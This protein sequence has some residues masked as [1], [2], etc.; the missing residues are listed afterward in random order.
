MLKKILKYKN[1]LKLNRLIQVNSPFAY[2]ISIFCQVKIIANKRNPKKNKHR[3]NFYQCSGCGSCFKNN[4]LRSHLKTCLGKQCENCHHFY[5][6]KLYNRHV[7]FCQQKTQE[8]ASITQIDQ[9]PDFEIPSLDSSISSANLSN[10][11]N[12][13][14]QYSTHITDST[15][16]S[17][18][19]HES[20]SVNEDAPLRS[21][22]FNEEGSEDE[23]EG[24]IDSDYHG[25]DDDSDEDLEGTRRLT[26][27]KYLDKKRRERE[28]VR[29]KTF[30]TNQLSFWEKTLNLSIEKFII[31]LV[32]WVIEL[33]KIKLNKDELNRIL[34]SNGFIP[35]GRF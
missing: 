11:I 34:I 13:D 23:K 21:S 3:K 26:Q 24:I 10:S 20:F 14:D 29:V 25:D 9:V 5:T 8:L 35:L 17:Q 1:I 31:I 28:S 32:Q 27:E 12:T 15:M 2:L 7:Q 22:E 19:D 30:F 16:T 6:I 33:A 18:S 4:A